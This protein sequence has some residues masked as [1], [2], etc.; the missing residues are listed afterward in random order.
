M[1]YIH[2]CGGLRKTKSFVLSPTGNF[3]VCELDFL[4]KCPVC[5]HTVL[6]LTRIDD[7][8]NISTIRYVNKSA[9]KNFEKF[10]SKILYE[11]RYYDYSRYS[12]GRFYLNYNEFGVKKRCYSNLSTLKIGLCSNS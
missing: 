10:K 7:K 5:G 8:D 3:V 2:C 1:G 12:G 6:Q 9:R 11:R 4:T